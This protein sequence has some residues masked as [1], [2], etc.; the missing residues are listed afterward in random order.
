MVDDQKI[1]KPGTAVSSEAVLRL[2]GD[3]LKYV[4]RGGL[5]LEKALD[6]WKLEIADKPC[7]DVGDLDGRLHGLHAAARREHGCSGLTPGMVRLRRS[8]GPIRGCGLMERTNA[9][10]LEAHSLVEQGIRFFR[11]GCCRSSRR[12]WCC[13]PQCWRR[14]RPRASGWRGEAGGADQASVRGGTG[15]CGQGGDRAHADR[16]AGLRSTV[17]RSRCMDWVVRRSQIIDSPIKGME[18]QYGVPAACPVWA[19]RRWIR[20]SFGLH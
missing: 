5:K 2:L 19:V 6:H 12:R 3:D 14:W 9:R 4:G 8:C 7:L 1:D 13:C 10:L 16:A 17:W 18:R 11:D 15:S 20:F